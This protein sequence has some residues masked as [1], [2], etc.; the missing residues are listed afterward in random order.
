MEKWENLKKKPFKLVDMFTGYHTTRA[1]IISVLQKAG[2]DKC[3]DVQREYNHHFAL[4]Q[5]AF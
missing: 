4:L 3:V 1:T 5:V 2:V